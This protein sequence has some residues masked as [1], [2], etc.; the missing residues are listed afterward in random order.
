MLNPMGSVRRVTD[1][2]PLRSAPLGR[3]STHPRPHRFTVALDDEELEKV[4]K[5][6]RDDGAKPATWAREVLLRQATRNRLRP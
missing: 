4:R 2:K 3:H 1:R 5:A 6:G